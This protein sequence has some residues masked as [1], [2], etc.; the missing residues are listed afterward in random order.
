MLDLR[1]FLALVALIFIYVGARRGFS[2]EVIATAGI[3]LA[4]FGLHHFDDTLRDSCC[5][6]EQL[7]CIYWSSCWFSPS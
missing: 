7:G 4:L 6:A 3:L 1:I 2:Q 5:R